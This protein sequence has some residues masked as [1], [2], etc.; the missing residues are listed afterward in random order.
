[1]DKRALGKGLS[2]L[3]PDKD[4]DDSIAGEVVAYLNSVA[5]EKT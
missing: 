2:A 5:N 3:I 4:R 1:M